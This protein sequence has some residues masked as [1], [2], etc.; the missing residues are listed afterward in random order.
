MV[1]EPKNPVSQKSS[2]RARG[3]VITPGGARSRK[4]VHRVGPGEGVRSEKGRAFVVSMEGAASEA[5][6]SRFLKK[7]FVFTPGGPRHK[8]LV[9]LVE[10]GHAVHVAEGRPGLLNLSTKALTQ[11]IPTT[12]LGQ[13][14]ALGSGWIAYAYWNNGT[15]KSITSFR[16]TWKVPP[17]PS[18]NDNQL[19]YLFNGIENFGA[20]YGIL[21]PV[22]QWGSSGGNLGGGAYWSVASWY[23]TS[24]GN[25]FHTPHVKVNAGDTVVGVMTLTS[26]SG[27][28][29]NY[30][31][32][33]DGIAGTSL[34]VQN[35]A[36][37]LWC[38]ETL[39]A[40]RIAGCS[41]YPA[42]LYTAFRSIEIKTGKTAPTA[43]WTPV[44]QVTDCGQHAIVVTDSATDG[45]VDIYYHKA[46]SRFEG[47]GV[48]EVI[49]PL[50]LWF[51]RHGGEDPGWGRREEE[52]VAIATAVYGLAGQ[53]ASSETRE[54]LRALAASAILEAAKNLVGR[55]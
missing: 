30:N 26:K 47:V 10:K 1:R 27:T 2:S 18:D 31:C 7:D 9:H 38:N 6:G 41:D 37:L 54:K 36:E 12:P 28:M 25:A 44:N 32:E 11:I 39:E 42:T 8:S 14:P 52:Q 5:E 20:N 19:I 50:L 33:F 53:I 22:L 55:H 16:T 13:V 21:Q 48:L 45:E 23:V 15:G 51:Y 24:D 4:K 40:Y 46:R 43:T 17:E 3:K 34:P 49:N 35:I 29:F